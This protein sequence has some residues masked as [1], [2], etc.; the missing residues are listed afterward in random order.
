MKILWTHNFNPRKLNAGVFMYTAADGIRS[1]G[2]DIDLEYL[3]NL[4]SPRNILNARKRLIK[5]SGNYDVVHAQY[6]SACAFTT[7]AIQ[8]CPKVL[9]LRGSDWN[10][11]RSSM[12]YLYWHTRMARLMTRAVIKKYDH[13]ITV[14]NRMTKEL[15]KYFPSVSTGSFP[16]PIDLDRFVPMERMLARRSLGF[17]DCNGKWVLFNSLDRNNPIKRISLAEQAIEIANR[18]MGNIKLRVASGLPFSEIPIFVASCDLALCT[19]ENE[20]WPNSV[21]EALAC[22]IPF[23]ATDVSDL[24]DIAE[25]ESSCRIC[26]PD[27]GVIADNICDVVSM[28]KPNNLRRYVLDMDLGKSSRKLLALYTRM[29]ENGKTDQ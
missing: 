12:G 16:S 19:S 26:P 5:I 22:N 24:S 11:H 13:V 21:K 18:R 4:R 17:P 3:G 15:N 2:V 8:N 10:I 1:L 23:I 28:P 27:P 9:S 14:S 29:I 20:G 6:G 25:K 7:A